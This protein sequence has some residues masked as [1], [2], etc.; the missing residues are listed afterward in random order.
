MKFISKRK[1]IN[2]IVILILLFCNQVFAIDQYLCGAI[3]GRALDVDTQMGLA[4]ANVVLIGTELGASSDLDGYFTIN[5]VP[6]GSYSI[7]CSFLGYEPVI[8]TDIIVRPER[9]SMPVIELKGTAIKMDEVVV[10]PTYFKKTEKQPSSFI[11]IS[12]EEIRR[13][14]GSGGDVSRIMMS[15][16][17]VAKV[18]DMR[19][20]LIVRG[21]S[22]VENGYCIDNIAI[23]N[24]NHFPSQGA[25]SGAIGL[26][27]VD[28]IKDAQFYSGGFS[29]A[30]GDKL[31]SLMDIT[32][33]EG[34]RSE[35]DKQLDLNMQGIGGAIEGPLA[36]DRGSWFMSIRR[37][38]VD[39]IV[40]LFA[41]DAS[42]VP[43]WGDFQ[44]KMTVNLDNKNKLSFLN[45]T[46]LDE[47]VINKD[48]SIDNEENTYGETI[49]QTNTG[50]VNW[51]NL[52]G[53]KGYSNTSI[54]HSYQ[55]WEGEWYNS[56][57]DYLLTKNEST[58]QNIWLKNNSHWI[59]NAKNT[60][61][62]GVETK[63][64]NVNYNNFYAGYFDALGNPTPALIVIDDISAVKY[65]AYLSYP[66]K[67]NSRLSVTPGIRFDYFD[68]NE[69]SH[70][71]PRFSLAYKLTHKTTFTAA[72]GKFNQFLPLVLLSQNDKFKK[73][74]DPVA[75]HYVIGV[76]HLLTDDSRLTVELYSKEYRQMPL[77]PNQGALFT[78]DESNLQ[79]GFGSHDDLKSTGRAYSRGV[80][81]MIQKKLAERY[82][83][84]ISGSYFRTRYRGYDGSWYDRKY[85]NRFMATIDGGYKPNKLWQYSLRWTYAGG[86]P[87]TPFDEAASTAANRGIL[88]ESMINSERMPDYHSLSVRV[89]R[90]FHYRNSNLITY[91]S[92][93][94]FYGRENISN[95]Y[96]NEV[97]NKA[98]KLVQWGTMPVIGL[99]WEF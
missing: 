89:D 88:D 65:G 25:S 83:G 73:L 86:M 24:I 97:S 33:R 77:D 30:F 27:N 60:L 90:R 29:A 70:V 94:N 93:W 35:V 55:K 4:G 50:G 56:Q 99:E 61:D 66:C 85:D 57:T 26:I 42:T 10:K 39:L 12:K 75:D 76:N 64:T 69:N 74:D 45:L 17:S 95:Y 98:D 72:Y 38:Y 54:S 22:P 96:W 14:S 47:S 31:G 43:D 6:I 78:I 46:G 79:G 5:R 34:N 41:Q 62:F 53:S 3:K 87:Y 19:N 37:A 80:E 82:Y 28:F 84:V 58:E 68:Y 21:G 16:P 92:I 44:G 71:S 18:N 51:R 67:I 23:P 2:I 48:Q 40:G 11:N 15:L 63:L 20:S 1:S 91:L 81:I 52:W 59:I 32:F 7:E 9:I 36:N 49:W 8:I 13:A